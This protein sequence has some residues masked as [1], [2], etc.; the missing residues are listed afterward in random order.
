MTDTE[1]ASARAAVLAGS[2]P[3]AELMADC[4]RTVR[5]LVRTAGLPS[6]YSP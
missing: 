2:E 5:L 6:H 1:Y 4:L 3:S